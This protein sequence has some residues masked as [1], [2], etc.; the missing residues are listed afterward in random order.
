[1]AQGFLHMVAGVF[2]F[3]TALILMFA[4]DTVLSRTLPIAGRRP[5]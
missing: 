3:A 2:V 4:V 5:A 1:V